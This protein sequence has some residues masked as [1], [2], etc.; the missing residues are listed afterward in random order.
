VKNAADPHQNLSSRA[1]HSDWLFQSQCGVEGPACGRGLAHAF[2]MHNK[3]VPRPSRVRC[4]RA[5]LLEAV[6]RERGCLAHA[7][8]PFQGRRTEE[9][10]LSDSQSTDASDRTVDSGGVLVDTNDRL[11]HFWRRT[12]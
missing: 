11:Q 10:G 2:P 4:E 7:T 6:C 9:Y 5:G 8:F 1:E 3:R 12:C